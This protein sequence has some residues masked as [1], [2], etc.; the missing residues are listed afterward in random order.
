M[1]S[2]LFVIV[3]GFH[4]FSQFISIVRQFLHFIQF[5]QFFAPYD[6]SHNTLIHLYIFATFLLKFSLFAYSLLYGIFL[7][8]NG[9]AAIII[10]F[11]LIF[12]TTLYDLYH[13]LHNVMY[14]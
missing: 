4:N 13:H 5:A 1:L 12:C 7:V 8:R 9:L 14:L 11:Y 6:T 3:A 10:T 2:Q